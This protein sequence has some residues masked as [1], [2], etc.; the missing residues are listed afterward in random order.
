M[1]QR[2]RERVT[3]VWDEESEGTRGDAGRSK[4]G[5]IAYYQL[6]AERE[7]RLGM[8]FGGRGVNPA[9]SN[10]PIVVQRERVT[11]DARREM[12]ARRP[13]TQV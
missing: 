6:C 10:D 4:G 13:R 11:R 8:A 5:V 2:E 1:R 12:H 9:G 3:S 7:V